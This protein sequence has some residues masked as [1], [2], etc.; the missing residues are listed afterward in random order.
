MREKKYIS[1]LICLVSVI[2]PLLSNACPMCQGGP[3]ENTIMAYKCITLF[4][5]L[6]PI[7]GGGGIF[8]WI[9]LRT[10]KLNENHE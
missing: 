3:S 8:Y 9:Y 1:H 5:A 6:M 2:F 7:V 4:L 10:K